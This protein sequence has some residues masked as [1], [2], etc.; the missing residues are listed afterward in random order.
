ME[1]FPREIVEIE[2]DKFTL[3]G[4]ITSVSF[5]E[6]LRDFIQGVKLIKYP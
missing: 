4:E 3:V 5:I 1:R 2:G 6:N